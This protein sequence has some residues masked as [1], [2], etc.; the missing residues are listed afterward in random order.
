MMKRRYA[1]LESDVT[2]LAAD[3]VTASGNG[4]IPTAGAR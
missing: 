1:K 3:V 2:L 4:G